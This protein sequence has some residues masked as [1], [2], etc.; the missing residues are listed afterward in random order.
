ME[1]KPLKEILQ[2]T[3]T[4]TLNLLFLIQ[5]LP[6]WRKPTSMLL[7][8]PSIWESFQNLHIYLLPVYHQF[9]IYCYFLNTFLLNQQDLQQILHKYN[10]NYYN[11]FQ[12]YFSVCTQFFSLYL[13]CC[14]CSILAKKPNLSHQ[15]VA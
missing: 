13:M 8:N 10:Q 12:S 11:S 2:I 3:Q 1:L 4:W 7:F 6:G 14:Q 15:S 5:P 9:S